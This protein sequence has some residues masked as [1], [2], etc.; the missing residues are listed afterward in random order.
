M[1]LFVL[2]VEVLRL[3]ELDD[4][5]LDLAHLQL[6]AAADEQTARLRLALRLLHERVELP[7]LSPYKKHPNTLKH[8]E[9]LHE[10][11]KISS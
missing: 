6:R 7:I 4:R 9:N 5:V 8:I 3:L 11:F 2:G 10:N 1:V